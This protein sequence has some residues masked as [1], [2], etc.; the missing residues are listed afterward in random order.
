M[1]VNFINRF[2]C[3]NLYKSRF[4]ILLTAI[5]F[6]LLHQPTSIFAQNECNVKF[7]IKNLENTNG[8]IRITVFNSSNGFPSAHEKAYK[9]FS[10]TAKEA[11]NGFII[12]LP[13]GNYAFSVLHDAN[14]DTKMNYNLIGIPKEGYAFSKIEKGVVKIPDFESCKV[15]FNTPQDILN[16][17][18]IYTL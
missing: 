6:I 5:L 16:L 1:N 12:K 15:I 10:V 9:K 8:L 18:M 17:K 4:S 11:Q 3:T 13:Y 7:A 2:T 14:E